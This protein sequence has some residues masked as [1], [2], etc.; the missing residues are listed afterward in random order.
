MGKVNWVGLAEVGVG[1]A[2]DAG[3]TANRQLRNWW[4][5]NSLKFC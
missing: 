1:T 3:S 2:A 5:P 4:V